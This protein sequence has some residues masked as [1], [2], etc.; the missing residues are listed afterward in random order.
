[1]AWFLLISSAVFEAVWAS[2]LGL[3]NGFTEPI[4]T[5]VFFIALAI[6]L[7]GL[8]L[9]TKE[10]PIGTGYAVW[11]GIG[12]ALTVSFAMISGHESFS[13]LKVL[14]M[15]GIVGAVIGLKL[16]SET[17]AKQKEPKPQS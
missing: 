10:I 2:A 13:W 11:V 9:A 8:Y 6:S 17:P 4:A 12:S 5:V 16:V 3:S 14:F 15:A 1:M 7:A